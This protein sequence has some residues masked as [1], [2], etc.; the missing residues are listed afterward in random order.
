MRPI[1][2]HASYGGETIVIENP[3]VRVAVHKRVTGWGWAEI[4]MPDGSC[5]AILDHLGELMVRDQEI[6]MRLEAQSVTQ[7]S[8]DFG[9]RLTFSVQSMVVQDKL[10]GTSFEPWINYPLHDPAMA[11]EVTLTLAPDKPLLQLSYRLRSKAN[12]YVR[13]VRGPWLRV[14]EG[15]F[16]AAKTD[17]ILPGVE[18]L[19]DEEWSS[20]TDWFKDPWAM[21]VVPHPNKVAIPVMAVSYE[22]KG[23]GLAWNPDK[24][25]T[26]WFN[27]RRHIAQPVFASP[28][29][30]DRRNHHLL[31][32]MV[33]QVEVE[34]QENQ[35]YMDP[36]LEMHLD[37]QVNFDAEVFLTEGDSLSVIVDWVRRHGLP[38]PTPR[39][40][41]PEALERI[42]HAYNTHLWHL[43]EGF[44]TPQHRR[45]IHPSVPR[46]A[47]GYFELA[48][49]SPE[50]MA[51]KEKVEWCR[52]QL[53]IRRPAPSKEEQ[54]QRGHALI[55]EQR[56]DGS[57]A[58]DPEGRHYRKDDFIVACTYLEPMGLAQDTALDITI[59]PALELL[60]LAEETGEPT[61][62]DAAHKALEYCMPLQRPE[63]GDFWET[64]LH[65]PNLLAAG[66]AAVAYM[67]GYRAFDDPRYLAKAIHWI[68][69][70]L[71][72]TH[73][74]EPASVKMLYNTKPC[75]CSSDWFFANWVRDHV[76]WEVLETFSMSVE[77]GIDWGEIDPEIDWHRFH[78]GVSVAALRWMVDHTI[79]NWLP[80]N[81]P[82]TLPYFQQGAFDEC[83]ADT[84]NT[85]S[86]NYGG[87]VIMPDAIAYNLLAV[88]RYKR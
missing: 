14:G 59:L 85:V 39:W 56:P 6:P 74:W 8:G 75:L 42:A 1:Y 80:H 63:G 20:G 87:M 48:P 15:S 51:L 54:L 7:T 23:I 77:L 41:I 60:R 33:P 67:L 68:R 78:E 76:Q 19:L 22:G 35:V 25:A 82:D 13:Y 12:Q 27:Y 62:R 69:A 70:L 44:G 72:F 32:L 58:F 38:E 17:G 5:M 65:S 52:E 88:L 61:F 30:V 47:E 3:A 57:F 45:Q 49:S 21:R 9:Q 37:Q 79:D 29:F 4:L 84:H 50:A 53:A 46:F 10:R 36:P 43:G 71:P 66:H 83:F 64:P 16:G 86:G 31:G 18:W 24:W 11:G 81:L 2:Q 73:L 26:G 40:P 55:A 34:A 28:N